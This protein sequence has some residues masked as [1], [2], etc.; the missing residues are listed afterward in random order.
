[1]KKKVKYFIKN[2]RVIISCN[3]LNICVKWNIL[4]KLISATYLVLMDY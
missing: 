4:L 3:N 2:F 1:M